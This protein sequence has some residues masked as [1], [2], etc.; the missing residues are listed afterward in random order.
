MYKM[1]G[2]RARSGRATTHARRQDARRDEELR[3]R[4]ERAAARRVGALGDVHGRDRARVADREPH[5]EP[6][7]DERADRRRPAERGARA[8]EQARR[9]EHRRPPPDRVGEPR[10]RE[11]AAH[12]ADGRGRDDEA[13]ANGPDEWSFHH[14]IPGG[15]VRRGT[16]AAK[17]VHTC[18]YF[19]RVVGNSPWARPPP[20]PGRPPGNWIGV[21][22]VWGPC[23]G[24]RRAG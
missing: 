20:V 8:H 5:H 18:G 7:G 15:F 14:Q 17:N 2:S 9:D 19:L 12:R 1:F 10:R 6:A 24:A 4:R 16:A 11:R 21:S 13:L 3:D 22:G 23:V